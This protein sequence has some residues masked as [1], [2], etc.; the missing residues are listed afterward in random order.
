MA[1]YCGVWGQK[2]QTGHRYDLGYKWVAAVTDT[3][4]SVFR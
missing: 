2:T 3:M 4:C 1:N